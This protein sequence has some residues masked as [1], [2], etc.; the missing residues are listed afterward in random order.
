MTKWLLI[1]TG[2]IVLFLWFSRKPPIGNSFPQYADV[3]PGLTWQ[4]Y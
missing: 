3:Y 4:A 2:V 1:G